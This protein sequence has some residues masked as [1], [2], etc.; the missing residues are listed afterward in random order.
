MNIEFTRPV[1]II[2]A[3]T[4]LSHPQ[5]YVDEPYSILYRD[6]DTKVTLNK[7]QGLVVTLPTI[8]EGDEHSLEFTIP[9][10]EVEGSGSIEI[11]CLGDYQNSIEVN[12][13]PIT[14][15]TEPVIINL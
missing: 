5:Y 14:G 1:R 12:V 9:N 2:T 8:P 4:Q 11:F 3:V 15:E 6:E 10:L 13:V 7:T